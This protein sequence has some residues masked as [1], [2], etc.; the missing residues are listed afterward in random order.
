MLTPANT[1]YQQRS[2]YATYDVTADVRA[3]ANAVGMWLGN[4]YGS[5][6]SPYGFRWL[7]PKQ[8][9]AL[10]EVTYTDGTTQA[11]TTGDGW[12]WS[13]GPVIADDLYHGET[14]DARLERSGWDQPG[15][16]GGSGV[17]AVDPPTAALTADDLT[18]MRVVR[19]LRPVQL[20]QPSPGVWVYDL[21]QNIAGWQQLRVQGPSGTTVRMRTAEELG[22]DGNLD[23]TTN[24]AAASTDRFTLAGTG[25]VETYEPRFTYHGFRYLEVTGFPGTP[26]LDSVSGRVVHADVV[27]TG[28][29][30]SSDPLLNR[31]WE[32]N[33]WGILNNSMSLPTDNPV[34]DERTPPG[35]DVQAYHD[36]STREFGMDRFY[37]NYLLDMPPGTALPNDG[38]NN[39]NP[40]MGGDQVPLAWTLYE[41]YGDKAALAR[42]YPA[43]KAFVDTNASV[44]G[45]I[46]PAS[47]GFGDWCPPVYGA[48]VNDGRGS[49]GVGSCTSEVSLV[50]T[51]LSYRQAVD[52]GLAADAL[53]HP[54][55]AAR[56]RTLA[57]DIKSAF[58][59][60]FLNAA[61]NGYGSGR[62]TTSILPLAFG[63]VPDN[64]VKAV[65]DQLVRTITTTNNSH[66]DTGIF[67]TRFLVDALARIGRV[68]VAM[69]VLGQQTYPGFG[70]EISQ[71]ATSPWEE[72]TY[73]SSM[74]T[75]DHAMFSG[76][77]ASFYT[78]LGGITPTSAGY[79]TVSIA[80]KVPPGLEHVCATQDTVRG[81]VRSCWTQAGRTFQ[82]E[83][84]V[85]VGAKATVSVP[86]FGAKSAR[87]VRGTELVG[88]QDGAATYSVGSGDWKFTAAKP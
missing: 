26:T 88:V 24:R 76:I 85:P 33:R 51:A 37:A 58:N 10:V 2:L 17:R 82:L 77:N 56:F 27:S 84:T 83:V 12:T 34:R 13:S 50:N 80:P 20:T 22:A 21:G 66:L 64:D 68:D 15:W 87:A 5:R 70:Y 54:E 73:F 32:I 18:P 25:R 28:T 86:L 57:A 60:T 65:G 39:Q 31:I 4:G 52:V 78:V 63:L 44:P 55:D 29:F 53:G 62:Q 49:P 40:D 38:P 8:A 3:G 42:H 81:E 7:G 72:W 23:T 36:A 61:R 9:I 16:T 14:Y 59:S 74:E 6:F 45:H 46:W 41:Q 1:P 79:A 75:H 30:S 69:T 48:G 67:G 11:V 19:T 35:M 71:G 43:M 47:R